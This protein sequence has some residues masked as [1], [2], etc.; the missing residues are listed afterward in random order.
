MPGPSREQVELSQL[1]FTQSWEDP[2]SDREALHIQPTDVL[3]TITSGACNTLSLLLQQPQRLYA[4]DINPSQSYLL[5]LKMAA[6][7]RLPWA[8]FL[9]FLG[10][11]TADKRW[12]VFQGLRGDLSTEAARWWDTHADLVRRGFFGQGRYE[13]FIALF[14]KLLSLVQGRKRLAGLLACQTLAE[15]QRYF[16]AVWDTRRWRTIF[17]IFFNKQVLARRGLAV[18]YFHFDDG[19]TSFAESFYRRSRRALW[20][21]PVEGNYFLSQYLTGQYR[22]VSEAPAYLCPE[23]Y[24]T[25]RQRLDDITVVTADVK[26]WLAAQA[27]E[28]IDCFSLSN[29]CEVM[30]LGDTAKTFAEVVRVARQGGRICFRNLI[31]PRTVPE[32]LQ[33]QIVRDA[34][35]SERLLRHDRSFIYA[36]V[37]A[38]RVIK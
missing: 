23:H 19:S 15:Q 26:Q 31:I 10:L 18:D 1:L 4:V 30:S 34:S 11:R 36:R 3:L 17:Q 5:E 2:E 14:R 22:S 12:E 9:A 38:L 29:I 32:H 21:L 37:D 7:R 28:S 8:D 16:D 25:I 35:L 13:R 20:E 6:M 27:S 33:M 24:E